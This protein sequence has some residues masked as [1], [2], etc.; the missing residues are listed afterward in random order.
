MFYF[1]CFSTSTPAQVAKKCCAD[2]G[3]KTV[4]NDCDRF[5]LEKPLI[6]ANHHMAFDLSPNAIRRFNVH[7]CCAFSCGRKFV[8]LYAIDLHKFSF[9]SLDIENHFFGALFDFEFLFGDFL[10]N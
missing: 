8:S 7:F 9:A 4:N 5:S 2:L 10:C 1:F 3:A 6:G